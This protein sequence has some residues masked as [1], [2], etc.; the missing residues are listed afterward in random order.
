[1]S[2]DLCMGGGELFWEFK[3][4]SYRDLVWNNLL[5]NYKWEKEWAERKG[6]GKAARFHI[7]FHIDRM[8]MSYRW[9]CV[10]DY[11]ELAEQ[12]TVCRRLLKMVEERQIRPEDF[13]NPEAADILFS[14]LRKVL[15]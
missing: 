6:F 11:P 7:F 10:F 5:K 1:M 12:E 13:T 14:D 2:F 4:E 9:H 3:D 15:Q 8:P